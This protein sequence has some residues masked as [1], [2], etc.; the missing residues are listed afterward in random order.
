MTRSANSTKHRCTYCSTDL[1]EAETR[2]LDGKILCVN[3]YWKEILLRAIYSPKN[4]E[5]EMP[6][7]REYIKEDCQIKVKSNKITIKPRTHGNI[8]QAIEYVTTRLDIS[9]VTSPA[10]EK[11]EFVYETKTR[12]G[13]SREG[14]YKK[15]VKRSTHRLDEISEKRKSRIKIGPKGGLFEAETDTEEVKKFRD[16]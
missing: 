5:N 1:C 10:K 4:L 2:Q 3:C 9:P 11:P 15:H 6:L 8:K 13:V 12:L 7:I 14:I 16:K